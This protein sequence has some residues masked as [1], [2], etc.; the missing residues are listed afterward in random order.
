MGEFQGILAVCHKP[1]SLLSVILRD[2]WDGNPLRNTVK[3]DPAHVMEPQLTIL[4][5]TTI[6]DLSV[7]LSQA[8][9][10][11]GFAN[12]FL[13]VYVY[14][15]QLLP[16]G[17]EEIDWR[18]EVEQLKKVLEFGQMDRRITFD[19]PARDLWTRTIYPK[20]EE[21][22]PGLVGSIIS[23]AA[24]HILRLAMLY[25]IFD[26]SLHIQRPHLEAAYALWR[27]CEDSAKTIFG[28][29]LS[30]EQQKILDHLAQGPATKKMLIEDCF[31]KNR[32]ADLIQSDL[33]VLAA[34]R[35]VTDSTDK[36]G[37]IWWSK[38][39]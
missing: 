10:N 15:T 17:G 8:D 4:A 25:A 39:R 34:Q 9:R 27:Y 22:V 35:K 30:P 37:V 36:K 3:S 28:D 14:R 29:L 19:K 11:N 1:D 23:R 24:A 2:G 38:V 18:V 6:S 32:K 21:D 13:W 33:N 12:R 7:S 31:K 26:L 16:L 20:V 5:D